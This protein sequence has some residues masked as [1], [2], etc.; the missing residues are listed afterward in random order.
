MII[1]AHCHAGQ[2][3]IM[4]APANTDAPLGDYLRRARAA[5][6]DRTIVLP[7]FQSDYSKGNARLGALVAKH[8][9]R[10][11]GFAM[12]HATRDAGRIHEMMREAVTRW[13]F[14]GMKV[15]GHDAQATREVCEAARSFRLPILLDVVDQAHVVDMLAPQYPDVNFIIPHLGSFRDDYRAQQRV[16]DQ[17]VRHPNVYGDTSG[18]RRFDYI[19]QA[20]RRAGARKL[21]FG[22]DGPWL[23]P[24]VELHKIRVLGLPRE[25]ENLILGG[26]A[27]RLMRRVA[28]TSPVGRR[29]GHARV[30]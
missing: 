23:H 4:T 26:N 5:G 3:D 30:P 9:G 21:L 22:T 7:A 1:D 28:R 6:I 16:V 25:Q 11:I 19:V 8:G 2:G 10:L 14:R 29:N 20:V 18:V 27:M 12:V 17:M 15:H 13:G 24:S